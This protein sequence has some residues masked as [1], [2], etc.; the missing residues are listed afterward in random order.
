MSEFWH[1]VFILIE[2][3]CSVIFLPD[4]YS[5]S[6]KN[7]A[8]ISKGCTAMQNKNNMPLITK[9]NLNNDLSI[10]IVVQVIGAVA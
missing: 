10:V 9:E 6:E 5:F 8:K 4:F 7:K 2:K 3:H 1:V